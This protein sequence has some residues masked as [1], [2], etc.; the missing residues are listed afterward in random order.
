MSLGHGEAKEQTKVEA[1]LQSYSYV[2]L[3]T[4]LAACVYFWMA[5]EVARTR[6]K[7]GILAPTMS[8]DPLL[9][10]TIRAH[11]NMLEWLPIF[12]PA[13]WLFAIYW[14]ATAAAVL[15][16]VWVIGRIVYFIGYV[17]DARRRFPGFFIQSLAAAVLL[18]G[19]AGRILYLFWA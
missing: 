5:T 14:N 2:S 7:V 12:L 3:V 6:K 8:G 15:G 17:A 4:L 11:L 18:L 19:A 10:R 16:L 13:L 9:E 1:N